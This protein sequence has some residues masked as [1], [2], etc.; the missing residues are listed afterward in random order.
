MA[1]PTS[2]ATPMPVA[3][4]HQNFGGIQDGA[5]DDHLHGEV[6]IRICVV[7]HLVVDPGGHRNPERGIP[8]VS[9]QD[10]YTGSVDRVVMP[11]DR[12]LIDGG[13]VTT[14]GDRSE[15]NF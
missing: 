11:T 14:P 7:F 12:D 2:M 10:D 3:T 15:T 4:P 8:V 5:V 13:P 9:L 1:S 6:D